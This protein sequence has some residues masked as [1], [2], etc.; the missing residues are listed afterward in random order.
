MR[1]Q[2]LRP[3]PKPADRATPPGKDFPM[4]D[5]LKL[6][7]APFVAPARGVLVVF[8]GTGGKLGGHTRTILGSAADLVARA[9]KADGFTGKAGK[10][11]DLIAPPGLKASRLIVIG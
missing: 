5:T 8:A 4:A 9:A 2:S 3:P 1:F 11:L 10:S 7:F 6:G